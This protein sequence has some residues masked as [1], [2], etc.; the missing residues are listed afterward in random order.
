MGHSRRCLRVRLRSPAPPPS[1]SPTL[2]L[3]AHE[4]HLEHI[5][6]MHVQRLAAAEAATGAGGAHASGGSSVATVA[7][8]AHVTS[9]LAH[10]KQGTSAVLAS[11]PVASDIARPTRSAPGNNFLLAAAAQQRGSEMTRKRSLVAAR[12]SHGQGGAEGRA[13]AAPLTAP[14]DAKEGQPTGT[15]TAAPAQNPYPVVYRCESPVGCARA[16]TCHFCLPDADQ[17]GFTNAVRRPVRLADLL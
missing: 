5:R 11:A 7:L 16:Y 17:E 4:V 3:I 10:A 8:P 14:E 6:A 2:Q 15:A 12:I 9:Q 1:P 13:V